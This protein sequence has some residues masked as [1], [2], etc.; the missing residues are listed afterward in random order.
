MLFYLLSFVSLT[1]FAHALFGG[2]EVDSE[3]NSF[4][5]T[6][7]IDGSK[8]TCTGTLVHKSWV[9]TAAHCLP[10][11]S[12]EELRITHGSVHTHPTPE[13]SLSVR[14]SKGFEAFGA[15]NMTDDNVGLIE[16]SVAIDSDTVVLSRRHR[17]PGNVLYTAGFGQ[18]VDHAN[19]HPAG[20]TKVM[21]TVSADSLCDVFASS[22]NSSSTIGCFFDEDK[23]YTTGDTGGPVVLEE[24]SQFLQIAVSGDVN[25]DPVTWEIS[26]PSLFTYISDA[27]DWIAAKTVGEVKCVD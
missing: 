14:F 26:P 5:F 13:E 18:N 3:S 6:V 7:K 10:E 24:D 12:N 11:N 2:K 16:L 23:F 19:Q 25:F 9:L 27:C 17:P 20:L 21:F 4:N 1:L 15:D 22:S 8:G